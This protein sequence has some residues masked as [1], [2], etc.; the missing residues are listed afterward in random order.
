[1][2]DP[3]RLRSVARTALD[4]VFSGES[5]APP[6]ELSERS[7]IDAL[8]G[9]DLA[10]AVLAMRGAVAGRMRAEVVE[11]VREQR[12]KAGFP[13]LFHGNPHAHRSTAFTG[14]DPATLPDQAD[15]VVVNCWGNADDAAET[16]KLTANAARP[17]LR[18]VS[19][20]LAIGGM[21]AT[22]QNAART[23]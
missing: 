16:V 18:V 3:A 23:L 22:T 11:A 1:G 5:A 4:R 12:S 15:G 13:V 14:L 6:P 8:L 10:A 21:G 20:M 19:G 7:K 9:P 2:V 17:G